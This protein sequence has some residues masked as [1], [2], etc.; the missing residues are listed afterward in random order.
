M[1]Y[2]LVLDDDI[3]KEYME[4]QRGATQNPRNIEQLLHLYKPNHLTNTDQLLRIGNTDIA[5]KQALAQSGYTSQNLEK[6]AE[7][8]IYKLIL[9]YKTGFPYVD[10]SGTALSN[11]YTMTAKPSKSRDQLHDYLRCLLAKAKDVLICDK[12]FTD[13]INKT[14]KIFTLFPQQKINVFFH[15]ER[16]KG[17]NDLEQADKTKVKQINSNICFPQLNKNLMY[18]SHHDRYLLIDNK[19]EIVITSGIENLFDMS[20]ECTLVIRKI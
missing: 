9:S 18:N 14:I 5:L 17:H 6:L 16:S 1:D 11:H 10:I 19:I 20:N 13:H 7:E 3:L 12:Y 4:F 2:Y 15:Q 8:T